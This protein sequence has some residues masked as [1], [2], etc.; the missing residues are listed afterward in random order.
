MKEKV[1]LQLIK[2]YTQGKYSF[3][4]LKRIAQWFGDR[5]FL[6]A[7]KGAVE[8]HWTGFGND[9]EAE[10]EDLNGVFEKLWNKILT[11]KKKVRLIERASKVYMKIAAVLL[12]PLLIYSAYSLAEYFSARPVTSS[13]WVEVVSPMGARTHFNL[14]DGTKVSLN[15]GTHLK[16]ASDFTGNRQVELNGEAYFDVFHDAGSPFVVHTDVLDVRVLGTKFSVAALEDEKI[17]EVILEQGKVHV[18]GNKESF[19]GDLKANE[20]FYYN[21]KS[22]TGQIRPVDASYLTAWKDGLLVFRSEP[23]GE[24]LK[25]IGRWYHVRFDIADKE[26]EQF[27]YRATFHEEPLEEVLRLIALTAPV[28]YEIKE[29]SM[30]QNGLYAEKRITVKLKR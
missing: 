24:V 9:E 23:L 7:M 15:S 21:K 28:E 12:L 10:T 16:Y 6:G 4:D 30:D 19:S 20:G 27:Y 5:R 3:R 26:I 22:H 8:A 2:K 13:Q 14:P 11:E 17:T 1:D 18:T 29:R 25:R